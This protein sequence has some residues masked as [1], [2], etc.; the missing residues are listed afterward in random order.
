V[1]LVC[2]AVNYMKRRMDDDQLVDWCLDIVK[3]MGSWK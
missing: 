3:G 1:R 2:A